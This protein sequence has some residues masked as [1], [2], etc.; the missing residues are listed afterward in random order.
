MT[1]TELLE[2]MKIV[3]VSSG[4][5]HDLAVSAFKMLDP[6]N[7]DPNKKAWIEGPAIESPANMPPIRHDYPYVLKSGKYNQ[8]ITKLLYG[9]LKAEIAKH[10]NE[11][12]GSPI[13]MNPE[14]YI[15]H[16]AM[17]QYFSLLEEYELE[18]I[19]EQILKK[20]PE[21]D[22][23]KFTLKQ[24]MEKGIDRIAKARSTYLV[25]LY[26]RKS[27]Q[28]RFLEWPG[29]GLQPIKD[30][31]IAKYD[32]MG[33][34][35]NKLAHR[36]IEGSVSMQT[37]IEFYYYAILIAKEMANAFADQSAV[38]EHPFKLFGESNAEQ[39]FSLPHQFK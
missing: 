34:L 32:Q 12:M 25:S 18:H 9:E 21:I 33:Q 26:A 13:I 14:S 2:Q 6:T 24:I 35:R 36:R 17:I 3:L 16:S 5:L 29:L 8:Y 7:I 22:T 31:V 30:V 15:A 38:Y 19:E 10:P 4:V 39:S 1:F 28:K 27:I 11:E 20:L 23:E 37:A